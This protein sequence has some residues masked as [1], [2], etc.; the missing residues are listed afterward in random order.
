MKYLFLFI[1]FLVFG[2]KTYTFDNAIVYD[3]VSFEKNPERW[4][5]IQFHNSLDNSYQ[6][7]VHVKNDS[8]YYFNLTF[9]DSRKHL[10]A[11]LESYELAE[12][13]QFMVSK[14]LIHEYQA[15]PNSLNKN[16]ALTIQSTI[17][18]PIANLTLQPIDE[19]RGKRKKLNTTH[20]QINKNIPNFKPNFINRMTR[21]KLNDTLPNFNGVIKKKCTQNYKGEF[22]RCFTLEKVIEINT[23]VI[24]R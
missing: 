2:Q 18:D 13:F 6:A 24:V 14:S 4:K 7:S 11:Q 21:G 3:Y 15:S 12:G 20:Y 17:K 1:P 22:T 8:T 5:W 10:S 9:S 19:K 23:E 16:F